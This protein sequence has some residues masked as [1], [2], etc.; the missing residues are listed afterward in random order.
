MSLSPQDSKP[1]L[2]PTSFFKPNL[3]LCDSASPSQNNMSVLPI[4]AFQT[5]FLD[6][7]AGNAVNSNLLSGGDIAATNSCAAIP[8]DF[9]LHNS[10]SNYASSLV[11]NVISANTDFHDFTPTSNFAPSNQFYTVNSKLLDTYN[12][13]HQM[14]YLTN[15]TDGMQAQPCSFNAP[16]QTCSSTTPQ[17]SESQLSE[18][19]ESIGCSYKSVSVNSSCGPD[20]ST[21]YLNPSGYQES[22]TD[23]FQPQYC[24]LPDIQLDTCKSNTLYQ[25]ASEDKKPLEQFPELL[26]PSGD[27]VEEDQSAGAGGMISIHVDVGIQC[28]LGPETLHAF[29]DE[30]DEEALEN[31]DATDTN[32]H[33][34]SREGTF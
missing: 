5:D 2:I 27:R 31:L 7:S 22:S 33:S 12:E 4:P 25:N 21:Y 30:E 10:L 34:Q 24:V 19:Y 17:L 20:H 13:V 11:N 3:Q 6:Q 18:M 32:D 14:D 9:D 23:H 15:S 8:L 16:L 1:F 28:E 26:L 29:C